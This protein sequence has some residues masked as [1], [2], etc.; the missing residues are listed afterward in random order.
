[1][2]SLIAKLIST[3]VGKGK[4]G[5]EPGPLKKF[6]TREPQHAALPLARHAEVIGIKM[7]VGQSDSSQAGSVVQDGK[8]IKWRE[9]SWAQTQADDNRWQSV[10]WRFYDNGLVCFD[11][12]MSNEGDGMD[13]GDMQGHRIELREKAG[14]LLGTWVAGFYVRRGL[15]PI[16]FHASIVD[17]HAP[18]KLHFD[19]LMPT[20]TGAWLHK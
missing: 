16:G 8:P 14:L 11:A 15:P 12:E 13:L 18:L 6:M 17:D 19:D 7:H 3:G 9:F 10:R 5:E 1:M 4:D 20:Q 2:L